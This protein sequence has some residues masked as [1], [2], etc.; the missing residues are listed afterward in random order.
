MNL[1]GGTV[2]MGSGSG[3]AATLASN[4]GAGIVSSTINISGGTVTIGSGSGQALIMGNSN[5]STGSTSTALNVSGGNV[6][7]ATTG[8]TAVTMANA[9]SGTAT[10]A[11]SVTGGSLAVQGNIVGGAGAG[12]RN[13]SI[14][15]NGG[16]LDMTSKIIGA[17]DN[18]ITF[19]AK[20]GTLANIAQI[21][22]GA[23]LTKTAGAGS[24]TLILEGTNAYTGNTLVSSGTLQLG[25]GGTTGTLNTASPISVAAG[26][27]FAVKRSNTT[28]QGTD[29][30]S[31]A[32][33]GDGGFEQSGSG[34]TAFTT[35]NTYTGT[36]VVSA[37]T[38]QLGNGGATGSLATTSAISVGSG[39]TFAVNRSD[40]VTQGTHFSSSAIT[41]LGGFAQNGTGMTVLTLA[42]SYSGPTNVSA[43]ILQINSSATTG[44]GLVTA[45]SG[46]VLAG[47]G[48]VSGNLTL[49][50]G[51][52]L[53][54][55]DVTFAGNAN[56]TTT[57]IGSLSVTGDVTLAAGSTTR[58]DLSTPASSDFFNIGGSIT[59]LGS[60]VVNAA[61]FAPE[62]GQTFNLIEW[63]GSSNFTG[64]DVG[65]YGRSGADDNGFQF[66]LPDLT[67][68]SPGLFWDVS[69]FIAS[70]SISI[71]P[72]PSRSLL[73][74]FGLL[75]L[76]MRR[77]RNA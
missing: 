42:N 31:A 44:G 5:T 28:V 43:G 65:V 35:A 55:G 12:A 18:L 3:T 7:L 73:L 45:S 19:N 15:L 51:G 30:S 76:F 8:A 23:G 14:T 24:N 37:G 4:T 58:F 72:E 9:A 69:N 41:G 48:T 40:I 32:I 20:S 77:R 61:S 25:S 63:G 56:T 60:I 47:T 52:V 2:A 57:G 29:F 39:A 10:A 70:G 46:G 74:L 11:I 34:L 6:T 1:G 75:A 68:Y 49:A 21:N 17:A 36:T 67:A 27:S 38:L 62:M 59:V 66:D 71:V 33:T 50:S 16:M 64:F 13:A 22:G 53:H 26:T 54:A